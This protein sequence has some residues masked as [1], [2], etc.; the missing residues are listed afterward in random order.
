MK[1]LH[2][3]IMLLPM[4]FLY[5]CDVHEWP[6]KPEKVQ[7]TIKLNYELDMTKWQHRYDGKK[8]IELGLGETY[9]NSREKG[10][11]RYIVRAY[12][13]LKN[14]LV[15]QD[16]TNE[17][18]FKKDISEGYAQEMTLELAPGDYSIV[19]WSDLV[20][21]SNVTPYYNANA[22]E[23]ISLQGEH[24]ACN[25]YRDAFRGRG[26]IS[27]VSDIVES[28]PCKIEINMQRPLA[29]FEF[30]TSDLTEFIRKETARLKKYNALKSP[31]D[32]EPVPSKVRIEDYEVVFSYVGFMPNRYSIFTDKPVDSA[33]GVV[34]RT[35]LKSG[36][37]NETSIGFDY[38]FV[39]GT[40][41]SVTIQIGICDPDGQCISLT[42]PIKVPLKRSHHTIIGGRFLTAETSGGVIINPDFDGDYNII[43]Q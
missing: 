10:E 2:Y 29:K 36:D 40:E 22:F 43:F 14:Q 39:N 30:I 8:L 35:S 18:V 42:D 4:L 15:A 25:D 6:D 41:S 13:I 7:F 19:V 23:E 26:N 1:R 11:I 21:N 17:F 32:D 34:F 27:L 16:Y 9:D 37:N 12:P 24:A 31:S 3:F 5:A 38:V 28:S 33:T 20:E